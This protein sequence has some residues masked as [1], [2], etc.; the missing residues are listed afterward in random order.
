MKVLRMFLVAVFVIIYTDPSFAE[1]TWNYYTDCNSI[2]VI[3]AHGDYIWCATTSG[4]VRWNRHDKTYIHEVYASPDGCCWYQ[5]NN[6]VSLA[7]D[8]DGTAW[9]GNAYGKDQSCLFSFDGSEWET[10]TMENSGLPGGV[11]K[12]GFDRDGV[13]WISTASGTAKFN[14]DTWKTIT[15]DGKGNGIIRFLARVS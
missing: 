11:G 2:G 5:A 1:G 14:G 9:L 12:L 6:M 7:V 15:E 8:N 10:Y 4:I 3:T 13:L